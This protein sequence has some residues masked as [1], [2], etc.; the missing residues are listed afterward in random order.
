M[1]NE[2][3]E[4][5][6]ERSLCWMKKLLVGLGSAFVLVGVFK[7]WP[8]AEKSYMEFIKDDGYLPMMIGFIMIV[9]GVSIRLLLG[10]E[11]D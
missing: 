11:K 3:N 2:D 10:H 4:E 5:T 9:L 6:V 1:I 8:I 7:Q